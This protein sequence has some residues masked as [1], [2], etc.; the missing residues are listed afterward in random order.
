MSF[1]KGSE[2]MV[3]IQQKLTSRET[4][5]PDSFVVITSS[6][7]LLRWVVDKNVYTISEF[8]RQEHK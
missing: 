5:I 2:D 6:L 8:T 1:A 4:A 7:S 3:Q